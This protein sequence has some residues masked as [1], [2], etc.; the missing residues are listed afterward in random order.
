MHESW[1]ENEEKG[2]PILIHTDQTKEG[3]STGMIFAH[4][5]PKDSPP[6]AVMTLA[7]AIGQLGHRE[8][9]PF[10]QEAPDVFEKC[11]GSPFPAF[12]RTFSSPG[13]GVAPK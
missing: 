9:I 13:R 3:C 12:G 8:V 6:Y 1:D 5:V 10:W 2:M 7:G 11:P 4:I